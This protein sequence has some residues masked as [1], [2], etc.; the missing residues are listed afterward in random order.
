[1]GKDQ[2]G[3]YLTP[4]RVFHEGQGHDV[5]MAAESWANS[6]NLVGPLILPHFQTGFTI[7]YIKDD[8]AKLHFV[9]HHEFTAV[10]DFVATGA[11]GR[12][13]KP[14]QGQ[15]PPIA[16]MAR[17]T[18]RPNVATAVRLFHARRD[19]WTQLCNVIQMVR[20]GLGTEIPQN[21]V[22]HRKLKLLKRTAQFRETAGDTARHAETKVKP[23]PKPMPL[24]EAQEIV[25]QILVRWLQKP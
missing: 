13:G 8:G 10:S 23:P 5:H 15:I 22:S 4:K 7:E 2:G 11:V 14:V 20:D 24:A 9:F 6:I 25:R 21:W 3:Y 16:L 18:A 12:D 17:A 19:D 1:M